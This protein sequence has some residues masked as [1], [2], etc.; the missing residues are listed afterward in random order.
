MFRSIHVRFSTNV[1]SFAASMGRASQVVRQA[2]KDIAKTAATNREFARNAGI[3]GLAVGGVMAAGFLKASNSAVEFEKNMRNVQSITADAGLTARQNEANFRGM[4]NAVL[5]LTGKLPQN[6]NDLAR[7][8]YDIASSGFQGAEGLTVLREAAID[9]SAGLSTTAVAGKA[10]TAVLNAYGLRAS[11]AHDVSDVLFQTVKVGVLTFEDLATTLGDV[12]GLAAQAG[13][14]IDQVGS[15]LATMT[16]SGLSAAE[17]GTSL[18]RVLQAFIKPS[19]AM[20]AALADMGYESGTAAIQALGLRGAVDRLRIATGGSVERIVALFEEIRGAR[21]ALAL[22]AAEGDNYARSAGE[23][24]DKSKRAQAAQRALEEQSKSAAYQL[25]LLRNDAQRLAIGFGQ[26]LLPVIKGAAGFMR[27]LAAGIELI[28]GPARA[29]ILVV[30]GMTA[31]IAL[32]GGSLLLLAPRILATKLALEAM[33]STGKAVIGVLP[34]LATGVGIATAALA[35]GS[36]ALAAYAKHKADVKR[37]TD[38]LVEA[39]KAEAAGEQ[40]AADKAIIHALAQE[41]VLKNYARYKVALSDVIAG[42]QLNKEALDGLADSL[43]KQIDPTGKVA[44]LHERLVAVLRGSNKDFAGLKAELSAVTDKEDEAALGALDFAKGI[45]DA[46]DNLSRATSEQRLLAKAADDAKTPMQRV[47]EAAL[48]QAD[49]FKALN[50]EASKYAETVG[51]TVSSQSDLINS[52]D[53]DAPEKTAAAYKDALDRLAEAKE[54]QADLAEREKAEDQDASTRRTRRRRG[55]K[56]DASDAAARVK[57]AQ[58]EEAAAKKVADAQEDVN[59]LKGE[60]VPSNDAQIRDF[61]KNRLADLTTFADQARQV[62]AKGLDPTFLARLLES[63]PEK[64]APIIGTILADHSGNLLQIVNEGEKRLKEINASVVEQARLTYLAVHAPTQR[65]AEDLAA[66][67]SISDAIRALGKEATIEGVA[68]RLGISVEDAQ[69]IGQEYGL[70]FVTAMQD[71]INRNAAMVAVPL[72]PNAVATAPAR[73]VNQAD[74]GLLRFARGAEDHRAFVAR[75]GTPERRFNEPETGG[76]A[77]IPLAL[78]KRPRSARILGDVAAMFGY[79][80]T[81]ANARPAQSHADGAV[82][83]P[84]GATQAAG[85]P[86]LVVHVVEKAVTSSVRNE[87]NFHGDM[88]MTDPKAAL[89]YAARQRRLAAMRGE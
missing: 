78:S 77:Y 59:R 22:M 13:V 48:A 15:A 55:A 65:M 11:D 43:A 6:A 69:R 71:A 18:N 7:G 44:H 17:S 57:R 52:F 23:I 61:Y 49:A 29:L 30:G 26:L 86:Q 4:S 47:N 62:Q 46:S 3:V 80:L 54:S 27:G 14:P 45:G 87:A 83:R 66:A 10:L 12:V 24:E 50:D 75:A 34:T 28:P 63:G 2:G 8:L 76:E 60:V 16:L 31:V 64:A 9:A 84:P 5:G 38:E 73:R 32:F 70:G 88:V 89:A 58:A 74:G 53:P 20:K 19:D 21:G 82:V 85:A 79:T 67:Q 37:K 56:Q 68:Q 51:K 35:I 40:G 25:G 39:L 42:V 1:G 36:L 41:G 33:G 72:T 81:R